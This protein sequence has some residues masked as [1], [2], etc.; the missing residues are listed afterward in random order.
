[1]YTGAT[2][3][4]GETS[5]I[6]AGTNVMLLGKRGRKFFELSNHLGNVLVTITDQKIW[7]VDAA[8]GNYYAATV[9]SATDYYAFGEAIPGRRNQPAGNRYGFNGKEND[10]DWGTALVQDYGFRIYSGA[11]VRFYSEDPITVDY[12][13]LTTYQFA[14]N[15]PRSQW[16]CKK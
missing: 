5:N 14:S 13:E 11:S 12:P 2:A 4:A 6:P 8:N 15:R 7:T 1:M 16:I 3:T 9:T 10:A